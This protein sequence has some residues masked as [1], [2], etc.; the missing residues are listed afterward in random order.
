MYS[1]ELLDH[2]QNPRNAGEIPDA[3]A[4]AQVENPVCG[5]ILK[6]TIKIDGPRIAEVRFLAKGCVPV[7][8]CGSAVTEL[9]TGRAMVEAKAIRREDVIAKVGGVPETSTHAAVLAIDALRAALK[10]IEA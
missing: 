6:L 1:P 10:K 2:F 4:S 9:A 8:A 7:M 3:D 5:D